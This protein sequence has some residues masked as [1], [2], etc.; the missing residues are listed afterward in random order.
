MHLEE[1]T[2]WSIL[3]IFVV[4]EELYVLY[5]NKEIFENTILL[6]SSHSS[7]SEI[8]N[9]WYSFFEPVN[10]DRVLGCHMAFIVTYQVPSVPRWNI[11]VG[12]TEMVLL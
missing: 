2:D 8:E 1:C 11:Y 9:S 12:H 10:L 6:W 4:K 3:Y 7:F 5:L